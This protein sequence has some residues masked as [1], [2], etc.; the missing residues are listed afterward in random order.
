[1]SMSTSALT[2][3]RADAGPRI[4]SSMSWALDWSVPSMERLNSR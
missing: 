2:R 1:M 3:T 4:F